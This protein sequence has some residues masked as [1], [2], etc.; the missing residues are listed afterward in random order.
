MGL[1]SEMIFKLDGKP[2]SRTMVPLLLLPL[3]A[4]YCVIHS[5]LLG[6]PT[7][8]MGSVLWAVVTL[9][10]WSACAIMF[11]RMSSK[12]ASRGKLVY[13]ALLLAICAY[14]ASAAG[15]LLFDPSMER[16]FYT[17]LPGIAVAT[18]AA[19]LYPQ[20]NFQ[21]KRQFEGAG[22][23]D[24]PLSPDKIIYAE[25]A[26][27]YVELHC[28]ARTEVWRQTMRNAE[29]VLAGLGFV[30]IHRSFIVNP[31]YVEDVKWDNRRPSTVL[32]RPGTRLRVSDRYASKAADLARSV[33]VA[34]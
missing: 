20:E 27:N 24:L 26:G 1:S 30:R 2:A 8:V 13:L 3:G 23:D 21:L 7:S 19:F 11:V 14:L 12:V 25:A 4:I 31:R 6:A 33:Q 16:A 32:L 34:G 5:L 29:R 10:P 22:S 9:L 17:R 28:I 15:A 18:F